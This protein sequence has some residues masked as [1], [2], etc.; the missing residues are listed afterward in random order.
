MLS[1]F[2]GSLTAIVCVLLFLFLLVWTT[3]FMIENAGGFQW[4]Y[5]YFAASGIF[6]AVML[7]TLIGRQLLSVGFSMLVFL[8]LMLVGVTF[9]ITLG[10]VNEP[11]DGNFY[12]FTHLVLAGLCLIANMRYITKMVSAQESD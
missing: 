11:S 12:A 4:S 8:Q 10:L 6:F 1:R 3:R 9:Y 7:L 5:R 2:L